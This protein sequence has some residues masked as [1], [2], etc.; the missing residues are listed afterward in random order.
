MIKHF[1]L[2]IVGLALS[3]TAVATGAQKPD[4]PVELK[5]QTAQINGI[6]MH[7]VTA[8]SGK[9]ILF[10]HGFPEFWYEWDK[11]LPFFAGRGYQVVAPDMRGY[12]LTEKPKKVEDYAVSILIEDVRALLGKVSPGKKAILVAHDW[13]GAIAWAFAS[14]HPEMLDQLIIINAPHP[15][16][17]AR[18]LAENPK[19][20]AASN[21]MTF[22][23]SPSAEAMLSVNNYAGLTQAILD[24]R[25]GSIRPTAEERKMYIDAWSQPGALTGGLNYYRASDIG[26]P[27]PGSKPD[28]NSFAGGKPMNVTVPTLVIWGEKDT[29]LLTGNLVGLDKYVPKLTIRRIPEGSHWVVH[30][31]PELISRLIDAFVNDKK[32]PTEK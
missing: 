7:Y 9:T 27:K 1:K 4:N 29:A 6:K 5:H 13:G 11:Q 25:L 26:P 24:S 16:V 12:N 8:G 32:L 2:A 30:E 22:F 20:Q 28:P 18:E 15:T 10:L 31:Q 14:A 23:K 19:Q 3:V 17:F 21:Y